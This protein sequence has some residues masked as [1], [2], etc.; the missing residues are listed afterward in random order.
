MGCNIGV[1]SR[2]KKIDYETIVCDLQSDVIPHDALDGIDTVFHLAGFAHDM[3]DA[4]K[5]QNI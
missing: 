3:N 5:I 1:L 2:I 4:T